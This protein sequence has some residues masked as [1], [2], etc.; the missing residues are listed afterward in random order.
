MRDNR[1]P[2]RAQARAPDPMPGD[3][4]HPLPMP[5]DAARPVHAEPPPVPSL[6]AVLLPAIGS[7]LARVIALGL[8]ALTGFLDY[9]SGFELRLGILYGIPVAL[10]TWVCGRR[11]GFVFAMLAVVAWVISAESLHHYS[12]AAYFFWDLAVLGVTLPLFVELLSRLRSALEHS[13]A[14]FVRVLEG[15]DAAVY[16]V[17][18]EAAVLYANP[19]LVRLCGRDNAPP[20]SA[21]QIAD[22]FAPHG[23][24]TLAPAQPAAWPDGAV[25]VDRRDHRRYAV[26]SRDIRWV[27]G[28]DAHLVVM[29]DVTDQSIAQEMQRDHQEALHRTA[30]IVALTEAASTVAHELNQPLAAI[31]GYSSASERLLAQDGDT[32]EVREALAKCHAQAVRAGQILKRLRELTRRR[33]PEFDACDV[34]AKVQKALAWLEHDLER[35]QVTVDLRL[36]EGLA[37]VQADRVLIEQVL[38]NLMQNA[39]DAMSNVAVPDRMLTVA[40]SVDPDGSTRVT[41]GDRGHGI[42]PDVAERL[43][44][45]FF[46][47]KRAGL[48]LGLSICRSIVEMHGGR[49]GHAPGAQGGTEFHFTFPRQP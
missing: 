21:A 12:H 20:A 7:G 37:P 6:P 11:W 9:V 23:D 14:R 18:A 40:T 45:P 16:V 22:R 35:A 38:L 41:I 17:D 28:R 15:I 48:G 26:Q 1:R 43:F 5:R 42:A 36:A 3:A 4:I 33:T 46:T 19:R 39:V 25:L 31:V 44:S 30:R 47:T 34:N 32:A 8:I 29:T 49:I 10:V 27:D 24:R 2:A 13:D